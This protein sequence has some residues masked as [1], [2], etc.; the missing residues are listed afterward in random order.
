MQLAHTAEGARPHGEESPRESFQRAEWAFSPPAAGQGRN[1]SAPALSRPL[2]IPNLNAHDFSQG[3]SQLP[4]PNLAFLMTTCQATP[5][6]ASPSHS[7]GIL[8]YQKGTRQESIYRIVH[9][10]DNLTAEQL[11]ALHTC[12]HILQIIAHWARPVLGGTYQSYAVSVE[13]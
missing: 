13:D 11:F 2:D 9:Q 10:P 1:L 4:Q 3:Q 5:C 6:D 7:Y 12:K 8:L